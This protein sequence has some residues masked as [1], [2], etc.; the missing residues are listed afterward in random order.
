MFDSDK[1]ILVDLIENLNE[2]YIHIGYNYKM[3]SLNTPI[4]IEINNK[5]EVLTYD[6]D[7][8]LN[9]LFNSFLSYNDVDLQSRKD[10]K[11]SKVLI[12]NNEIYHKE[13]YYELLKIMDKYKL[14]QKEK[15]TIL[16]LVSQGVFG[17]PYNYVS[18]KYN[19]YHLGELS[20]DEKKK[21][22]GKILINIKIDNNK[23]KIILKKKLRL[24][25][26]NNFKD[27]TE[28]ILKFIIIVNIK[29]KNIKCKIKKL[30][31]KNESL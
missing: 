28:Q 1:W 14:T 7:H 17:L 26:I 6:Y 31:N 15:Y 2:M 12:N 25:K 13:S 5:N 22:N 11:R 23:K 10:L 27:I 9:D 24:F 16:M 4:N 19:N 20:N 30:F 21:Y 18:N 8:Y 3:I 29:N